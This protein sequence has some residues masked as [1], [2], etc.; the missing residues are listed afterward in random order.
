[1]KRFSVLAAILGGVVV[2]ANVPS[3]QAQKKGGIP[4]EYRETVS[5][6]LQWL[7]KNQQPDG[8]WGSNAG[9]EQYKVAMT[10]LAGVA[11]LME[12]ST[13]KQGKYAPNIRKAV[14]WCVA[15]AQKNDPG[16]AGLI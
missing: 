13:V 8:H 11:L 4:K 9:N 1:M 2:L 6:G 5:K 15:R 14:D 3:A 12:G 7:A 10:G 16:K